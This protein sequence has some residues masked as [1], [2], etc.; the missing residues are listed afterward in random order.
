[1][2]RRAAGVAFVLLCFAAPARAG[3]L[4][5]AE[6]RS[7]DGTLIGRADAGAYGFPADGSVLRI[8][9]SRATAARVELRNVSMFNGRVTVRRIIVPARG[10]KGARLDGLVVDGT[11]YVVGANAIISL[12]GGSYLVALQEA[13]SPG[14]Q[15]LVGLARAAHPAASTSRAAVV[16]GLPQ[17]PAAQA[18]LAGVPA[19]VTPDIPTNTL[20]GQAVALAYRFLGAPYVWGGASPAGFDCSGLTMYVYAEVGIKLGHYTGFQY[21]QGRR[22]PRDQLQPGDLIFFHAN[23]SGVPG[24][25]G[26]YIGNGSFIHAPHTG[27]VVRISS[28]FETRYALSY[29]GGVRPYAAGASSSPFSSWTSASG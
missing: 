15:L 3:T 11:G 1:M 29:V 16:L 12:D 18:S 19:F 8:G 20:G 25:E 2:L 5:L 14:T 7:A 4:G 28:L 13:V 23:S 6:V 22:V 27:D 9:S 21:Y 24:H 17:L 10:L 26:M